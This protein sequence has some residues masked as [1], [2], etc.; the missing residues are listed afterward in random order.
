[1]YWRRASRIRAPKVIAFVDLVPAMVQRIRTL[2]Y[3]VVVTQSGHCLS[4]VPGVT[5]GTG[6]SR[7]HRYRLRDGKTIGS[8]ATMTDEGWY[9]VKRIPTRD[10]DG[11][12]IS[13][14]VGQVEHEGRLETA[15]RI[16]SGPTAL[17]PVE[18]VIG[19]YLKALRQTAEDTHLRNRRNEQ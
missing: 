14:F 18:E 13:L 12:N 3:A 16:D 10:I 15:I 2:I 5:I 11:K 6:T 1:M 9:R 17:V 8:G 4:V 7:Y 19:E